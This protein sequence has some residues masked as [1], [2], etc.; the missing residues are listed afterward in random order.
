M[1][2]YHLCQVVVYAVGFTAHLGG[3]VAAFG[4]EAVVDGGLVEHGGVCSFQLGGAGGGP[5]WR[6]WGNGPCPDTLLRGTD[7]RIAW[8]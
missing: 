1:R 2:A 4:D 3:D 5:G 6:R 8:H 7:N